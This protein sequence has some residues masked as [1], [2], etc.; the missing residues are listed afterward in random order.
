MCAEYSVY[1]FAKHRIFPSV[2]LILLVLFPH[3][4]CYERIK[5]LPESRL[6]ANARLFRKYRGNVVGTRLYTRRQ[7]RGGGGVLYFIFSRSRRNWI[8]SIPPPPEHA[9][10][11][12]VFRNV[13]FH[14]FPW[15]HLRHHPPPPTHT[16]CCLGHAPCFV[17]D[18]DD[19]S[20][21]TFLSRRLYSSLNYSRLRRN[22]CTEKHKRADGTTARNLY[23]YTLHLLF[24]ITRKVETHN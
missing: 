2:N 22:T 8:F 18:A 16:P 12:T 17:P 21:S 3:A 13:E 10:L 5:F 15:D 23:R 14:Q 11:Y 7:K 1:T 24:I 19:V 20:R 9:T 6:W 4:T